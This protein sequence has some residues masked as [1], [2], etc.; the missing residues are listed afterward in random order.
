MLNIPVL[1]YH[2]LNIDNNEYSGNDH[3]AFASDLHLIHG[4]GRRV[5]PLTWVVDWVLGRRPWAHV[6]GGVALTMDDGSCFDFYDMEHPTCGR[7]RSMMGILQDFQHELGAVQPLLQATSFVIA[8]PGPRDELDQTC[9]VNK[10]W[11]TDSWWHE[12][13]SSG[14]M[15]VENHSWDHLHPTLAR[16]AHSRQAKGD[17]AQVDNVADADA[18]IARA[19]HYIHEKSSY[20]PR[21]FAYP[22]GH[23]NDFL[24]REYLPRYRH[25]HGL[26]AAFTT[27]PRPVTYQDNRWLLPRYVCGCDWRTSDELRSILST[28]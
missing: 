18:Q 8:G 23:Y 22:T 27:E 10:G 16:V 14:L 17:F 15:A 20:T 13:A 2:S 28:N 7:Q 19:S 1:A 12:A 3:V 6:A 24:V 25:R 21:Y 4:L 26:F 5:I 11:W 9:L